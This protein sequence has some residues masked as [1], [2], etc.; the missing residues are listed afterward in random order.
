[1]PGAGRA[2]GQRHALGH[3][4]DARARTARRPAGRASPRRA[5]SAPRRSSGWR[6]GSGSGR[7]AAAGPS[8]RPSAASA[9]FQRST[10]YGLSSSNSRAW[11]STRSSAWSVVTLRFSMTKLADPPE[12]DRHERRDERL[13][14]R[15]RVAGGD[16]QVVDDPGPDV[17]R[18]VER[19]DRVG[20]LERRRRG[21]CH[22]AADAQPG[23]RGVLQPAGL[24]RQ[25]HDGLD[26]RRGQHPAPRVGEGQ[27][28]GVELGQQ[29]ER[30]HLE[31]RRLD[32]PLEA[33][34]RD[35]VAAA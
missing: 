24:G 33:V 25:L 20:H 28:A 35:V 22:V 32:D 14:R 31:R 26:G 1:M 23:P 7:G 30:V 17:V 9:S 19:G 5:G 34:G 15:L 29:A 27:R 2:L 8:A 6:P 11:R 16:D 12:V 4:D 13:E 18:E 21:R 10:R 3:L